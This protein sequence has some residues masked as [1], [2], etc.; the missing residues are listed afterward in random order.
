MSM[1]QGGGAAPAPGSAI[2]E[3]ARSL[4]EDVFQ[5]GV[6]GLRCKV[7]T[8]EHSKGSIIQTCAEVA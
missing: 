5:F 2:V 8:S 3:A 6:E 7:Q 1:D 4:F